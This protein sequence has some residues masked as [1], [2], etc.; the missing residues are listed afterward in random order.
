[1]TPAA[2]GHAMGAPQPLL[3][4]EGLKTWFRVEGG[5]ARSVDGGILVRGR[6]DT[7]GDLVTLD[8]RAMRQIRGNEIGMIFQEPMTS[9]NP[10][11][12]TGEQIAETIRLHQGLSKAAA[13]ERA[14]D[15][16]AKVGL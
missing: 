14:V 3:A 6:D 1:M 10:V 9:L 5:T 13:M 12:T 11:F 4:V 16:L 7:V 2:T 15:M 8:E